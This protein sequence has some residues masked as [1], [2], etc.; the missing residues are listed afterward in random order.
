LPKIDSFFTQ[1]TAKIVD[2]LRSLLNNDPTKLAQ[3]VLVNDRPIDTYLLSGWKWNTSRYSTQKSARETV[4]GLNKVRMASLVMLSDPRTE[5]AQQEMQSLDN[6]MKTKLNNYNLAK[7]SL[8]Q[9]QRKKTCVL[10]SC[11]STAILRHSYICL[12]YR[13]N[14]SVRALAEIVKAED[15]L[16]DSEYMETVLVAVPKCVTSG[17]TSTNKI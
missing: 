9:L 4:D 5:A 14:L 11:N 8:V 17:H 10:P 13:G 1:A 2:T 7:G 16:A 12:S 6:V 15:F 3:H